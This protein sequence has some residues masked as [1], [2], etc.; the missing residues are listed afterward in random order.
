MGDIQVV[1]WL[2]QWSVRIVSFDSV[3]LL[4]F[5]TPQKASVGMYSRCLSL[6]NL[7]CVLSD[8][9]ILTSSF[10]FIVNFYTCF[11]SFYSFLLL[12]VYFINAILHGLL[13]Q[14]STSVQCN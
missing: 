12:L 7:I 4:I 11:Y 1:P 5:C 14:L 8:S 9:A 2:S 3:V 6:I 13:I 10:N